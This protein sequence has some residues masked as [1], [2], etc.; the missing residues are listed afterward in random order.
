MSDY[1]EYNRLLAEAKIRALQVL[2]D[3]MANCTD[4]V[5]A[6]RIADA[7]LKATTSRARRSVAP[8]SPADR[9]AQTPTPV[10]R[11]TS[12]LSP[13]ALGTLHLDAHALAIALDGVPGPHMSTAGQFL[14]SPLPL[15]PHG[16]ASAGGG[17]GSRRP[18]PP[19]LGPTR[20]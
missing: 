15:T 1:A 19:P 14:A 3:L 10:P 11:L 12:P 16:E 13:H 5:E 9:P 6:R 7:I 8:E 17:P 2:R 18:L 4:P 20:A